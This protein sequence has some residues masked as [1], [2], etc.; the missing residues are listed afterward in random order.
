M[1]VL[2]R[3]KGQVIQLAYNALRLEMEE[4]VLPLAQKKDVG[5]I[6]R[7]PLYYGILAGNSN[8][9]LLSLATIIVRT[10]CRHPPC[11]NLSRGLRGFRNWQASL[12]A[13]LL[14]S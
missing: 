6:A 3:G 10:P 1:A 8:P 7:V 5:I 2:E 11:A 14:H 12:L 4:R 13:T 9:T